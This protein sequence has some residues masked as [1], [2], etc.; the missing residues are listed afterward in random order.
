MAD[1]K[2]LLIC[3]ACGEFMKKV[4]IPVAGVNVDVCVDGCGG[5]WFDNRE[6]L[7]FDEKHENIDEILNELKG[8]KF[9]EVDEKKDRYCPVCASKMVKN[10]CS[11]KHE[12][13]VDECYSCGG[14]FFDRHELDAMRAQYDTEEERIG[15][16]NALSKKIFG[17]ELAMQ[18]SQLSALKDANAGSSLSPLRKLYYG[19]FFNN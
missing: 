1:N 18:E 2:D 8:K 3:P 16:V 14:K 5:I 10:F 11:V 19:L 15:A 17:E 4:Y 7:K 13:E 9:V 12:I 6:D